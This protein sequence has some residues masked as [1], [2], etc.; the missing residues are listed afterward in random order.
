MYTNYGFIIYT[1]VRMT[2]YVYTS[3]DRVTYYYSCGEGQAGGSGCGVI[4]PRRVVMHGGGL[5]LRRR[6]VD[7][8]EDSSASNTLTGT[9]PG[10]SEVPRF[11]RK[12]MV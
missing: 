6:G 4:R 10:D 11:D 12:V 5:R 2:K 8:G 7:G 3:Q 9:R 1:Q